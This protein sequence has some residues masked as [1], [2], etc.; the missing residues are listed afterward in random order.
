MVKLNVPHGPLLLVA[1]RRVEDA[2][3]VVLESDTLVG[4]K[5]AVAPAG[6]PVTLNETEPVKP[7]EPLAVTV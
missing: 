5:V 1:I 3:V 6:N 4:L 7:L 2:E